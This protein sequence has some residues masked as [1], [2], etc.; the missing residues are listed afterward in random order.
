MVQSVRAASYGRFPELGVE[1]ESVIGSTGIAGP[2]EKLA[3]VDSCGF[4]PC[5]CSWDRSFHVPKRRGLD[6]FA[7]VVLG[8]IFEHKEFSQSG[9]HLPSALE[10]GPTGATQHGHRRRRDAR[11]LADMALL[12]AHDE[13]ATGGSG[14]SEGGHG[15]LHQR[16]NEPDA[17][18]ADLL[19]A[20]A[21]RSATACVG[22]SIGSF[23]AQ[24]FTRSPMEEPRKA[25]QRRR[26]T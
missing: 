5:F 12:C 2:V 9:W 15:A 22:R 10:I 25:P 17:C 13:G 16:A 3:V 26:W 1:S 21:R 19:G 8:S 14:C 23:C 4:S 7:A 20:D 24:S 6:A 11:P 18:R